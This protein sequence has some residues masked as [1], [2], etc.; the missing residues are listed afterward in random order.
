MRGAS[1][2]SVPFEFDCVR[3]AGFAMDP[4]Q[5]Q[6]F[7]YV[8]A[9]D[10]LGIEGS[11]A[12]KPD[13]QVSVP[14]NSDGPAYRYPGI[15]IAKTAS[16]TGVGAASVIGIVEKF[17]WGGGVGD[18]VHL[19]FWC[20]QVNANQINSLQQRALKNTTI[21]KLG[22]WIAD[23]DAETKSW[24]E[25]SYPQDP[26]TIAGTIA[27]GDNPLLDVDLAGAP[28]KDGVD[29]MVYK[30]SIS[31]APAANEAYALMFANSVNKPTAKA[32]GLQV[33]TLSADSL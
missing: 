25:A 11:P 26:T 3:E 10:G 33:G 17:T 18:A 24:Y 4:N 21:D 29:I 8:L 32:W 19:N 14:F 16:A 30:V 13:V 2:T 6:R 12:F 22:W 9:F 7:G 20:S 15:S 1:V 27:G 5:P 23:Y 28:V 31:V